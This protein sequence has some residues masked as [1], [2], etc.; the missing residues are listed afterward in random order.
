MVSKLLQVKTNLVEADYLRRYSKRLEVMQAVWADQFKLLGIKETMTEL[1]GKLKA[2][3]VRFEESWAGAKFKVAES[4]VFKA[5]PKLKSNIRFKD[6][7]SK[8]KEDD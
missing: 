7:T 5:Y 3:A 2:A 4:R 1:R 8:N 6:N